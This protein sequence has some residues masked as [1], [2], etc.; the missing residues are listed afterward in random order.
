M[1]TQICTFLFIII[2][3]LGWH[4]VPTQ[5]EP[6]RIAAV[7]DIMLAG[8]YPDIVARQG[9]DYPFAATAPLLQQA[10]LAIGNLEA[11]LTSGGSEFRDKRFRFRAP[12]AAATA[13]QRAGFSVLTLANNHIL[14]F[15]ADGLQDTV[16]TLAA[17]RIA[18]AGAGATRDAAR[19]P[20]YLN[21]AGRR[22]AILAYSLILPAKFFATS[23]RAGT[24][25]AVERNVLADIRRAKQQADL[26]LVTFHWGGE[27]EPAPRQS[28]QALARRAIDA[29]ATIVLGHHPHVL[30][31][32]EH[33][34]NGII[35]YSLGNF[36]FGSSGR[37]GAT[38]MIALLT[39]PDQGQPELAITP[40]T[41]DNRA[42]GY[43]PRPLSGPRANAAIARLNHQSRPLGTR[44]IA[45]NNT[46]LAVPTGAAQ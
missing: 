34:G 39:V 40:L 6:L 35:C 46:F 43:Q 19:A 20:V 14:D 37:P 17:A 26:V 12:P 45:S 23:E 22:I 10:H 36:T 28:Q 18:V 7:G 24:A 44:I 16:R 13:L 15:G 1:A 30:Q 9:A 32:I 11:P 8:R 42:T 33:Y 38:S 3:L 29:G 4:P 21:R 2:L 5:A 27:L 41:V 25:R 31:G